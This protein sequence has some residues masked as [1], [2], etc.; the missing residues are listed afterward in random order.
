MRLKTILLSCL[1]LLPTLCYAGD[2][3]MPSYPKVM[4]QTSLGKIVIQL[5]PEK[6]PISSR[7]FLEYVKAGFYDGT[8]FHRVMPGFM[9]QGGGFDTGF[10]QKPTRDPIRNEAD[11]GL[12][13]V[14]A[15]VAMARTSIPDS[16][17][18]QFFINTVDNGFLD[19]T[20]PTVQGWG[21]AVFGQ[22]VEGMDVVR[23]MENVSTGS[24]NGHQN[25][26]LTDIVIEKAT[27]LQE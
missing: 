13:N 22:V 19:H 24:R 5:D 10:N 7:N 3:T 12:K 20:S 8:I 14:R 27:V 11:N 21:Y 23:Q 17:T 6:A 4:L 18:S 15:S 25:V 1:I 9:A 16:A 26:P 2:Q